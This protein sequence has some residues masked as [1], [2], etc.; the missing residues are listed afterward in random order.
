M[1]TQMHEY[2]YTEMFVRLPLLPCTCALF[3]RKF[4]DAYFDA[5]KDSIHILTTVIY[6][7]RDRDTH[8]YRYTHTVHI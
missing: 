7:D 5:C 3:I 8:I 2:M 4:T 6:F 1:Q